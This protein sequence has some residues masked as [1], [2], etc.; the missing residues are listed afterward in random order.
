MSKN[1][2]NFFGFLPILANLDQLSS[3]LSAFMSSLSK[4]VQHFGGL[5]LLALLGKRLCKILLGN[6]VSSC[7]AERP[8]HCN[9]PY[10]II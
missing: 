6:L 7:H 3:N 1:L 4:S 5:P 9:L 8:S 10:L 2:L